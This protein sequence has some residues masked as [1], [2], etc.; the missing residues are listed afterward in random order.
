M[1]QSS[2]VAQALA[3]SLCAVLILVQTSGAAH[4]PKSTPDTY[5]L[6]AKLS[7]LTDLDLILYAKNLTPA[8]ATEV[9]IIWLVRERAEPHPK[10]TGLGGGDIT[11][12]YIQ[13]QLIKAL[14]EKGDVLALRSMSVDQKLEPWLRDSARLVLGN[15]Y[16]RSQASSLIRILEQNKE[17]EMRALAA[18]ALG[19][20]GIEKAVP[21]LKKALQDDYSVT[22]GN[23]FH[24]DIYTSYPVRETAEEAL[25]NMRSSDKNL[26][27][28]REEHVAQ[29]EQKL[30]Q[31]RRSPE[32]HQLSSRFLA[33]VHS[34]HGGK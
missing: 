16:D 27:K 7:D 2:A 31:A 28:W 30:K 17:G 33:Y 29:F 12:G 23:S 15:M 8:K 26:V 3:V 1:R 5:G 4:V 14:T 11:S 18:G 6:P 24:K 10:T 25:R 32:R 9:L 13:A 21:A 34:P 20:L 19:S 22:A